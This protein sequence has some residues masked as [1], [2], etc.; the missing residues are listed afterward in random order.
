MTKPADYRELIAR[1]KALCRRTQSNKST[2]EIKIGGLYIDPANQVVHYNG[3]TIALSKREYSLLH[4]LATHVGYTITKSEL[5]E[6]VWGI[7]DQWGEGKVVEVYVGYL[8][9]KIPG[10]ITTRK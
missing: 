4:Y 7:Y 6:K 5:L 9:K 2:E 8:R 1:L 3:E 10:I